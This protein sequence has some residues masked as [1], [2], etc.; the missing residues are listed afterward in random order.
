MNTRGGGALLTQQ[1]QME[2]VSALSTTTNPLRVLIVAPDPDARRVYVDLLRPLGCDAI[3]AADG[4]EALVEAL[5]R[6][7]SVVLMESRLPG[8]NGPALCEILRRDSLTRTVPILALAADAAEREVERILRAGATSILIK[9]V[10]A[11]ALL[12]ELRRLAVARDAV[13]APAIEV[14]AAV[15]LPLTT[16]GAPR[17]RVAKSKL[18]LRCTTTTPPVEPPTLRCPS[19]DGPLTYER[20]HL[21]GVSQRQPEQWDDYTCPTCGTFEYR[22]RTRKLRELAASH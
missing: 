1:G 3:E 4:R 18:H 10:A 22:H 13:A 6:R 19:C 15:A 5:V 2:R 17:K 21:G 16:T 9:P 20:S 7:P 11:D 12:S 14:V 8:V